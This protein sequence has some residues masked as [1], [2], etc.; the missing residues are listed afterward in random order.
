[1]F[2]SKWTLSQIDDMDVHFFYSLLGD[3]D[4]QDEEVYLS[5][6]W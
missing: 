2:E 1:M 3:D 5:D 6:I 4:A